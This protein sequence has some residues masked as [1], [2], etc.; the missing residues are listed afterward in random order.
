MAQLV[1]D[2]LRDDDLIEEAR[3]ESFAR[4]IGLEPVTARGIGKLGLALLDRTG[5]DLAPRIRIIEQVPILESESQP[6]LSRDALPV[7]RDTVDAAPIEPSNHVAMA[8]REA[9]L[10]LH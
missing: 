10:R 9:V 8:M 6:G 2:D 5:R 3:D 4:Q 7:N 1:V